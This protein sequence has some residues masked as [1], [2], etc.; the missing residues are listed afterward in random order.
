MKLRYAYL[1]KSLWSDAA[2]GSRVDDPIVILEG[3]HGLKDGGDAANVGVD[4]RVGE[5]LCGQVRVEARLHRHRRVDPEGG[6]EENMVQQLPREERET[7]QLRGNS[8]QDS[9]S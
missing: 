4:L 3:V 9:V 7:K 5:K 8:L 1:T 6:I 2:L